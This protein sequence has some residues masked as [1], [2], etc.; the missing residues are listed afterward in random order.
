MTA[1]DLRPGMVFLLDGA[2]QEV[3]A[4][5]HVKPGK[6][7][8]YIKCKLRLLKTG[9]T[10]E[11]S[12]RSSEK[13]DVARIAEEKGRYLYRDR[14]AGYFLNE[15]TMEE[16][17]FPV[18]DLEE[19]LR[20]LREGDEVGIKKADE[21][22]TGVR[23][24]DFVELKVARTVPGIKGDTVQS[25]RKPATLETGAVVMVPLFVNEGDAIRVDTRTAEYVTR[26]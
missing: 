1:N 13:V 4:F 18:A 23:L 8:A 6:G 24:P 17:Q 14:E 9:K 16:L 3:V 22:T 12:L 11:R 26:V 2:L 5:Q 21:K 10:Y 15:E 20:F 19:M 7:P 25:T